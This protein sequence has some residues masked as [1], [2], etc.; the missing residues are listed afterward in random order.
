MDERDDM[1]ERVTI[2]TD[3]QKMLSVARNGSSQIKDIVC[4][5]RLLES[6]CLESSLFIYIHS[7]RRKD[8]HWGIAPNTCINKCKE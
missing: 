1:D 8:G 5:C 2:R 6:S 4:L 3:L 7:N